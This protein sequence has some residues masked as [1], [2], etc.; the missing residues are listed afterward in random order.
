MSLTKHQELNEWVDEMARMCRP[1]EIV[2][3][4]GSDSQREQLIGQ[5]CSTGELIE[6][7]R[8]KLPGCYLHRTAANDVARTENLTFIC[9]SLRE[10]AG[11]NNNWMSP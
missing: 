5:A 4:D 9:T 10:D 3:I 6:L 1:Y 8:E 11:P 7:N 2:L